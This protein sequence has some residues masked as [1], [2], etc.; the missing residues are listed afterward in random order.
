MLTAIAV[1][2]PTLSVILPMITPPRPKPRKIMV[3]ENEIAPR[4]VANSA[5]TVGMTTTTDHIPTAPIEA[6]STATTSRS[7]A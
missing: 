7:Q 1:T 5:W 2:M 3:T 4:V 6:I